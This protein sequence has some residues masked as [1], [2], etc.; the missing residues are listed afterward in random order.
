M[1]RL[2]HG[3]FCVGCC[4]ALMLLMFVVGA[5]AIEKNV[6]WGQPLSAPPGVALQADAT[7][8]AVMH[9]WGVT[10]IVLRPT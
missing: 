10:P 9:L 4:C 2:R 5:M 7:V 6:S 3:L 8:L 1:L